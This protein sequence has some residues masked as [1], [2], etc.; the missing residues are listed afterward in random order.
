MKYKEVLNE[1]IKCSDKSDSKLWWKLVKQF[2]VNQRATSSEYPP[3]K[4]NDTLVVNDVDKA[5]L[6]NQYFAEQCSLRNENATPPD[7][8]YPLRSILHNV[9]I[10][11]E[12]IQNCI[13]LLKVSK[14]SGP[15]NFK[16]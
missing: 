3:M 1:K 11:E 15:D 5:E 2:L 8:Q 6:F 16:S 10:D 4:C 13:G 9:H 14:A 7:I 12:L